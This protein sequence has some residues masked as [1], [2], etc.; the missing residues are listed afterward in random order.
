MPKGNTL[1]ASSIQEI[2]AVDHVIVNDQCDIRVSAHGVQQV[3]AP[4]P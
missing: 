1:R 2:R 3:I 4:S